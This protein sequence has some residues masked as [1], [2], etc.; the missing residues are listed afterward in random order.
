M[1]NILWPPS[2][3][4]QSGRSY[5]F[6]VPRY[7]VK[8]G[9]YLPRAYSRSTILVYSSITDLSAD[10]ER[11]YEVSR[12]GCYHSI[13]GCV[14]NLNLTVILDQLTRNLVINHVHS[15]HR[16]LH[17]VPS[18][19]LPSSVA[20]LAY[21]LAYTILAWLHHR[22]RRQ[23]FYSESPR[24]ARARCSHRSQYR[25]TQVFMEPVIM[26]QPFVWHSSLPM[27]SS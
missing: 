16:R 15:S 5:I 1:A 10:G 2:N 3:D 6:V 25:E 17:G 22:L 12:G 18:C 24:Y 9:A 26:T 27:Q 11:M 14:S 19:R 7:F 13:H 20:H 21:Y 8:S 4:T 23:S